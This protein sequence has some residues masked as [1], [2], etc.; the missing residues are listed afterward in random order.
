MLEKVAL[1][2]SLHPIVFTTDLF[3]RCSQLFFLLSPV[4]HVFGCAFDIICT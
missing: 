4:T 3:A 1:D 2:K